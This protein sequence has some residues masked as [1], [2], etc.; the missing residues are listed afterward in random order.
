MRHDAILKIV[1]SKKYDPLRIGE[2]DGQ[3]RV[4][5]DNR[6]GITDRTLFKRFADTP[7][8]VVGFGW[9]RG[10]HFILFRVVEDLEGIL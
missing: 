3:V 9:E 4:Y 2:T 8:R 1:R 7:L 6:K 10:Q 5:M